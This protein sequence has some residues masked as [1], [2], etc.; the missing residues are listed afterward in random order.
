MIEIIDGINVKVDISPSGNGF[1]YDDVDI[2]IYKDN[3]LN[4]SASYRNVDVFELNDG[5]INI[6]DYDRSEIVLVDKYLSDL[7]EEYNVMIIDANHKRTSNE[8]LKRNYHK[9][10]K[11]KQGTKNKVVYKI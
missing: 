5:S 8:R 4:V 11:L 10:S 2:A 7:L 6:Y 9:I 1:I 3:A